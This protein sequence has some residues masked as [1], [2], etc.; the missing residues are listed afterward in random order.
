LAFL[1]REALLDKVEGVLDVEVFRSNGYAIL[2]VETSCWENNKQNMTREI[3]ESIEELVN[4]KFKAK[5][6]DKR[7][8][9]KLG[10]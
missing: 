9:V 8:S 10:T 5:F 4:G 6:H 7:I 1:I 2:K 3:I